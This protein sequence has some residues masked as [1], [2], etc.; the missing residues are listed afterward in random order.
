[1][2]IYPCCEKPLFLPVLLFIALTLPVRALVALS[3]D[4]THPNHG[5][6]LQ[7]LKF[8][9]IKYR[10]FWMSFATN[11]LTHKMKLNYD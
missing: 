11:L 9:T 10:C 5:L 4:T 8:E 6:N 1:M 2:Y 7:S 3:R